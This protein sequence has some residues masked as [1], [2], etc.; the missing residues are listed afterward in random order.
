MEKSLNFRTKDGYKI[1]GT[2]NTGR[3]RSKS[4]VIFVHGLTGHRNERHFYNAARFFPAKGFDTYR[5]DLYSGSKGGR[6]LSDCTVRIHASDLEIV[7]MHL[8][9]E[10][11]R[12]HVVGHS[13][14]GPTI[15][16]TDISRVS[17]I[18]LWDPS[19]MPGLADIVE[20][21]ERTLKKNKIS[22]RYVVDWGVEYILGKKMA[23]EFKT[24]RPAPLVTNIEKPIKIIAA[25][26][27]NPRG[28]RAYFKYANKPKELLVIDKASHYFDEEGKQERLFK[29]TLS[30]VKKWNNI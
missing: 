17:S 6:S 24:L 13:L 21:Q 10:Y 30:W 11:P 22:G 3:K 23:E 8:G 25:Q 16:L 29:E 1:Y 4:V 15:V 14:G 27:G 9:K 19:D 5:F 26:Y 2:L 7:M 20:G 12:M 28:S 18:V